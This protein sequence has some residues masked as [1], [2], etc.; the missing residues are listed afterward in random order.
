MVGGQGAP[1]LACRTAPGC[2]RAAWP[3][4]RGY[5]R[6]VMS[7]RGGWTLIA[8]AGLLVLAIVLRLMVGGERL[9][10]PA[11]D[12]GVFW[13]LR[14]DRA[15]LGIIVG[16]GLGVAGAMLQALMRNPLASPDLLGLASGAGLGVLVSFGVGAIGGQVGVAALG[17][18]G[19]AI[20]GSLGVLALVYALSQ[21]RGFVDPVPLILVGV[22]VS[23]ICSAGSLLIQSLLPD[24]GLSAAR[25]VLGAL[26]DDVAGGQAALVGGLTLLGTIWG[27]RLGPAMDASALSDDEA[28]AV[29]LSLGR[30]RATLFLLAGLMTAGSVVL[31]GPIGFVGLVCP[32][33]VRLCAGPSHRV[34]VV[35]SAIAGAALV[36]LADALVKSIEAPTGRLPI[37]VLTTIL[38]GPLFLVLLRREMLGARR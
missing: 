24:R 29:G 25:W 12:E 8:L 20:V 32:H 34:L 33:V 37:G 14:A 23:I 2:R 30:L 36:V 17:T 38:G 22:M 1:G 21:H 3:P 6:W 13:R 28:I 31:A 16:A 10:F 5:R 15:I 11:L 7:R 35:G 9:G 19:P 26:R 18:G 27:A 4:G